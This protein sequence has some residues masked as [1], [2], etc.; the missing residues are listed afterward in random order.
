MFPDPEFCP[1][2]ERGRV[3]GQLRAPE[4]RWLQ[5]AHNSRAATAPRNHRS[6]LCKTGRRK[7]IDAAF[8]AAGSRSIVRRHTA[9]GPRPVVTQALYTPYNLVGRKVRLH[10]RPGPTQGPAVAKSAM[11]V[12]NAGPLESK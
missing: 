2:E 1:Q 9:H 7:G 8:A 12:N 4:R 6:L 10:R 5:S 3:H 11:R